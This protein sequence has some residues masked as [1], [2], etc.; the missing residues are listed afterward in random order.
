M[1]KIYSLYVLLI[2]CYSQSRAQDCFISTESPT[3]AQIDI[4]NTRYFIKFNVTDGSQLWKKDLLTNVETIVKKIGGQD[5]APAYQATE[6]SYP[7]FFTEFQGKV[8]FQALTMEYG[9]ELW[10][11]DGTEEGTYLI[12]DIN[13]GPYPNDGVISVP[14]FKTS[15]YLFFG[16]TDGSYTGLWRTDGTVS[17]TQ[18]VSE[19]KTLSSNGTS[20]V[21]ND[22]AYIV[23]AGRVVRTDGTEAGT[24]YITDLSLINVSNFDP[25]TTDGSSIYFTAREQST[26]L[27]KLFKTSLTPNTTIELTTIPASLTGDIIFH[28]G[29]LYFSAFTQSSGTELW[30]SDG[31]Q[32]GTFMLK[33]IISGSIGSWP[34]QLTSVG[35]ILYFAAKASDNVP[36]SLWR[37]N[38]TTAGTYLV[39]N[40]EPITIAQDNKTRKTMISYNGLLYLSARDNAT[41]G[42]ELWKSNGT[43]AGT[44]LVKDMD[45]NSGSS[46]LCFTLFNNQ[47]YF[48]AAEHSIGGGYVKSAIW[49]SD[50]ST[51]GTLKVVDNL[52]PNGTYDIYDIYYNS[53]GGSM[54]LQVGNNRLYFGNDNRSSASSVTGMNGIEPWQ[55][56]GTEEG[57]FMIKN[58]NAKYKI[59]NNII[60]GDVGNNPI[61]TFTGPGNSRKFYVS[62]G[63]KA[64][65]KIL[66]NKHLFVDSD[67]TVE[68]A[69]IGSNCLFKATSPDDPT[70]GVELWNTDGTD[71]GTSLLK[72]LR[73]TAS[74]NGR[75]TSFVSLNSKWYF[76]SEDAK[77]WVSDGTVAGTQEV[78]AFQGIGKIIKFNNSLY[79]A[80]QEN[81][82]TGMELWKS[83]GSL[84]TTT[85]VKDI[86]V[87]SGNSSPDYLTVVNNSLFF[88]ANNGTLGNEL[89]K[90]D[91]TN[92]GTVLV[93]DI[94]VGSGTSS[95]GNLAALNNLLIFKAS[96][97]L[98]KS[99]GTDAGTV[100]VKSINSGN[101]NPDLLTKVG[102]LVFFRA[103]GQEVWYTDG[104]EANTLDVSNPDAYTTPT[105][106]INFNERLYFFSTD[107]NKWAK[108]L[109]N[110]I[111]QFISTSPTLPIASGT[112]VTLTLE[113]CVSGSASWDNGLGTGFQKTVSPVIT[114]NYTVTCDNICGSVSKSIN[115]TIIPNPCSIVLILSSTNVP[116]DDISSGTILKQAN[117]T[118]GKI[119]A[120][121]KITGTANVTYQAKS[122]ELNEGFKADNGTVFKAEVGGCN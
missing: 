84:A 13:P 102:N 42:F 103:N 91:G 89:W 121:N 82:T 26:Y 34:R 56:D 55:S 27:I 30:V 37:T 7:T 73:P 80:G 97:E 63:T 64:G 113:N 85:L 71:M 67:N 53:L 119:T 16:A 18:K 106:F 46:P 79:L 78:K 6:N 44:V 5:E 68:F 61:F 23:S 29:L 47:I 88:T 50:G 100:L 101:S 51:N 19:T 108:V 40:I 83:D 39:K 95:P 32:A 107:K 112:P 122:I 104:T 90:T 58:V 94:V 93:K 12:K 120:T 21:I 54:N 8:Y 20:F 114:T 3:T 76:K 48:F 1:K 11:S 118:T 65:T 66:K 49:K 17:G 75:P 43:S 36:Y 24:Y 115:V 33:D 105:N 45:A 86:N 28:N 10:C 35:N 57:T 87:G 92:T 96:G 110:L 59:D 2:F 117:S 9:R 62:D 99:D 81:T 116:T 22:V 41:N 52:F 77:L 4:A 74:L 111:D 109:N 72:D 25:I 31:T 70:I 98:Y 14:F 38:G 15:S 60:M 69:S